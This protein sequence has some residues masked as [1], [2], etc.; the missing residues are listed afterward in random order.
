MALSQAVQDALAVADTS[1]QRV[2][3]LTQE[4]TATETALANATQDDTAKG[5]ELGNAHESLKSDVKDL[6]AKL[7]TEFGVPLS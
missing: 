1:K 4:K 2:D 6:Y 3:T 5:N 7:A